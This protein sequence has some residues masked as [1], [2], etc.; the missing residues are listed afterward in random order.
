[1]SDGITSTG[2][3]AIRDYGDTIIQAAILQNMRLLVAAGSTFNST[4]FITWFNSLPTTLPPTSGQPW[5]NGGTLSF[6]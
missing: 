3:L 1:M 4:A 5:N 6:S 2:L